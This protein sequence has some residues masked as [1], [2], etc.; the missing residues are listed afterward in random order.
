M[1]LRVHKSHI[2]STLLLTI[3]L[4]MQWGS[5]SAQTPLYEASLGDATLIS[6]YYFGPNAF[7]VPEMLD[8]RVQ[9][10]LRVELAG[11]YFAGYRGDRTGDIALKVNIPL[12]TDRANLS[13]WMPAMEWYKN[14]DENIATCRIPEEHREEARK[15]HLSGDVYISADIQLLKEKRWRPDWVVRAA[16]KTA[17]GGE[18]FHARY[19]DSPGY[20]FDTSVGKSWKVG[21][22]TRWAHSLRAVLSTGFLCW[23]T[24]NGRQNDAVQFG[25]TAKWENR[26]FTLAETFAGYT[27]WEHNASH[28]GDA[29]HDR[30]VVLRTDFIAHVRQFDIVAAYQYGLRDYTYHQVRLGVAYRWD[31]LKMKKE[32]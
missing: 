31:I 30:P 1:D 13:L 3:A 12:W 27:G 11:D 19:Y 18:Y 8:G 16:L 7:P 22:N 14:S 24:D 17:S 21:H 6:P 5:A 4:T 25:V 29:A 10:D 23:Q 20:F 15:G 9:H 32:K 2:R 26:F 28:G